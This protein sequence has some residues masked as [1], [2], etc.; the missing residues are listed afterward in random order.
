MK[1]DIFNSIS[2][3]AFALLNGT[4]DPPGPSQS[5]ILKKR[6]QFKDKLYDHC[7][8]VEIAADYLGDNSV[9]GGAP[10]YSSDLTH[11]KPNSD[12][13]ITGSCHSPNGQALKQCPFAVRIGNWS[14]QLQV[15]GDRY[16]VSTAGI[17][18]QTEPLP[19]KKKFIG[20]QNC[21]GGPGVNNNPGGKGASKTVRDGKEVWPLPNVEDPNALITSPRDRPF[22]ALSSALPL[23][24]DYRRK[25][26]GSFNKHWLRNRWPAYP[27]DMDWSIF[28]AAHPHSQYPGYLKGD[29]T[30]E[31]YNLVEGHPY[32]SIQLPGEAIRVFL[33]SS[34]KG[35]YGISMSLDTLWIDTDNLELVLVWRGWTPVSEPDMPEVK[36]VLIT[37]EPLGAALETEVFYQQ[38]IEQRV[39]EYGYNRDPLKPDIDESEELLDDEVASPLSQEENTEGKVDEDANLEIELP[40]I[41]PELDAAFAAQ[42]D[43]KTLSET[44]AEII[45]E[46]AEPDEEPAE[47]SV[48][49]E[50][51]KRQQ[52]EQHI[53]SKTSLAEYDF[54]GLDVTGLDFSNCDLRGAVFTEQ[55]LSHLCFI[56]AD[57]SDARFDNCR[58]DGCT[59]SL[60]CLRECDFTASHAAAANFEGALL[61]DAIFSECV[62]DDAKFNNSDCSGADFSAAHM[63]GSQW[64]NANLT[65]TDFSKSKLNHSDFTNAILE[66]ADFSDTT[67]IYA[68]FNG[69]DMTQLRAAGIG[70]FSGAQFHNTTLTEAN[71]EGVRLLHSDFRNAHMP[72]CNLEKTNATAAIFDGAMLRQARF[73]QT[74]LDDAS[75]RYCDL[76]EV[77]FEGAHIFGTDLSGANAYSSE[78][79][80][81]QLDQVQLQGCNLRMTKLAKEQ[82]V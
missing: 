36:E 12:I 23:M 5:F 16:W 46:S 60:A 11:Y 29:E 45:A 74:I 42:N 68:L 78:F 76:F 6:Y 31:L 50:A 17:A 19:F 33:N 8:D 53:A 25:K 24:G 48:D 58:L 55:D 47:D 54:S 26:L 41:D 3:S 82:Q 64:Q 21:F 13:L 51:L 9:D 71:F 7:D 66:N 43:G 63:N 52:I 67:A 81:A 79:L 35:F 49:E 40:K 18:S 57:L 37:S 61:E 28:N 70:D 1:L 65:R 73:C 30:I 75:L 69:A 2:A 39:S 14:R 62:L 77:T 38:L 20:P 32:F 34:D 22:P 15:F 4:L 72:Y 27:E 59:F 10:I 44:L 56:N 80:D